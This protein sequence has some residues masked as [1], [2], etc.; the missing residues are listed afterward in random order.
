MPLEEV[1]R[2][3]FYRPD[4]CLSGLDSASLP[5]QIH[6]A[7]LYDARRR[8]FRDFSGLRE[9]PDDRRSETRKRSFTYA[10]RVRAGRSGWCPREESNLRTRFRKPLL[11]PLSYEGK[12]K[13]VLTRIV[14]G[15]GRDRIQFSGD[16]G[17][18]NPR[19][20]TSYCTT[21]RRSNRRSELAAHSKP[22]PRGRSTR[23]SPNSS[24]SQTAY[25]SNPNLLRRRR[26]RRRPLR[27]PFHDHV[28]RR[29]EQHGPRRTDHVA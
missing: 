29:A 18:R 10:N 6:S 13:P 4:R 23:R 3:A 27:D 7:T 28:G 14:A 17:P 22:T 24:R 26:N 12:R 2:S 5:E 16:Y 9:L 1:G 25:D 21:S 19:N 20:A 8:G 15:S 11:Y